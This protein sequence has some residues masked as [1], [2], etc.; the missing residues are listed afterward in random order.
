MTRDC[1]VGLIARA[2]LVGQ[3]APRLSSLDHVGLPP[4]R[5]LYTDSCGGQILGYTIDDMR[6]AA[7]LRGLPIRLTKAQRRVVEA[8]VI[9][10]SAEDAAAALRIK[11]NSVKKALQ[12]A[13]LKAGVANT[14]QLCVAWALGEK[15]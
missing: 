15:L 12:A 4:E 9:H 6:A 8:Y 14:V 3:P 1:I 7:G 10:G 2:E 5:V 11:E 13:R